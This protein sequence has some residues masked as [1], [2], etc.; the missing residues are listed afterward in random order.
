MPNKNQEFLSAL[1]RLTATPNTL[2]VLKQ[3]IDIDLS[4]PNSHIAF[5][6]IAI[7]HRDIFTPNDWLDGEVVGTPLVESGDVG[8]NNNARQLQRLAAKKYMELQV[9]A[10]APDVLKTIL[11]QADDPTL[12]AYLGGQPLGDFAGSP[13][14]NGDPIGGP[15]QYGESTLTNGFLD[16]IRAQ[17]SDKL[18]KAQ[19]DEAR[20]YHDAIL[21]ALADQNLQDIQAFGDALPPAD[22]EMQKI[23][24][25]IE[26]LSG[27]K[28]TVEKYQ[29]V[30]GKLKQGTP[31]IDLP[32][33]RGDAARIVEHLRE[34]KDRVDEYKRQ[35]A[36]K[37]P[38][39]AEIITNRAH[40]VEGRSQAVH[41]VPAPPPPET[42]ASFLAKEVADLKKEV[43]FIQDTFKLIELSAPEPLPPAIAGGIDAIKREKEQAEIALATLQLSASKEKTTEIDGKITA[44]DLKT[45]TTY[46][47]GHK[48]LN[49]ALELL[50]LLE[51]QKKLAEESYGRLDI[52]PGTATPEMLE[53]KNRVVEQYNRIL[54]EVNKQKKTYGAT[55]T[56]MVLTDESRPDSIF[57][58]DVV[59]AD[60]VLSAKVGTPRQTMTS[61]GATQT[62]VSHGTTPTSIKVKGV[63]LDSDQ[64]IRYAALFNVAKPG[65]SERIVQGTL[66]QDHTGKIEDR[67]PKKDFQALSEKQQC[68]LAL[69]QAVQ[70]LNKYDPN[71]PKYKGLSRH[72]KLIDG[73]DPKQNSRIWAACLYL[74]EGN[75]YFKKLSIKPVGEVPHKPEFSMLTRDKTAIGA[76]QEEMFT[77]KIAIDVFK[78]EKEVLRK[79][80]TH[81]QFQRDTLRG[82]RN[83]D[84][85]KK[86]EQKADEIYELKGPQK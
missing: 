53:D 68:A 64:G 74:T 26:K 46:I 36:D 8:G 72:E 19:I 55:A 31:A 20:G 7:N 78:A 37:R 51:E 22:A 12:R 9:E 10:A 2:P 67:T 62:T 81:A 41:M 25:V 27:L 52:P 54:A 47:L 18:Y 50:K 76:F 85:I 49:E 58:T 83:N 33:L 17:A 66:Y 32:G 11:S 45:P 21:A 6:D 13:G 73:P 4:Q 43:T 59:K 65:D 1:E 44:L 86:E 69:E 84:A 77:G 5:G 57:A 48:K 60:T 71:D 39:L 15:L 24:A 29:E 3:L 16:T 63:K 61:T 42:K 79:M 34:D 38:R 70:F 80:G 56:T 14:W 35:V 40:E 75:P 30:P 28:T 82:L 23:K